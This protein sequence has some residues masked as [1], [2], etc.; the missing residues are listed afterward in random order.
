MKIKIL[1]VTS[2]FIIFPDLGLSEQKNLNNPSKGEVIEKVIKCSRC[3]RNGYTCDCKSGGGEPI[4]GIDIIIKMRPNPLNETL[5]EQQ[6]NL[7]LKYLKLICKQIA[8]D[9]AAT[10]ETKTPIDKEAV[11]KNYIAYLQRKVT[12]LERKQVKST[13]QNVNR[14]KLF[15]DTEKVVPKKLKMQ[16]KS[17]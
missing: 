14:K 9:F 1:L 16:N 12:E 11:T 17:K 15:R 4:A 8:Q 10:N 13:E 3:G 5:I 7:E 6:N 2:S